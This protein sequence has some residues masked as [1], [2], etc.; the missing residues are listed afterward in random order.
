MYFHALLNFYNFVQYNFTINYI[1]GSKMSYFDRTISVSEWADGS[2]V[3]LLTSVLKNS[4]LKVEYLKKYKVYKSLPKC[5]DL[6]L[7]DRCWME[8]I[9]A[10]VL[11]TLIAQ[12]WS[13]E[14]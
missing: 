14:E 4:I 7:C 1:I 6:D 9:G 8:S 10:I 3:L 11:A 5:M 2:V 13:E 12:V